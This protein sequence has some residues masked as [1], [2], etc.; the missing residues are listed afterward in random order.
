MCVKIVDKEQASFQIKRQLRFIILFF[1]LFL[2]WCSKGSTWWVSLPREN[3]IHTDLK[4]LNYQEEKRKIKAGFHFP[5]LLVHR[6]EN[7]G[8]SFADCFDDFSPGGSYRENHSPSN[9]DTSDLG[10]Q[11]ADEEIGIW[12]A[13]E[14]LWTISHSFYIMYSQVSKPNLIN[15]HFLKITLCISATF[16]FQLKMEVKF[17]I[18][19][20]LCCYCSCWEGELI[21]PNFF[22][23]SV[24]II[25]S[26][27]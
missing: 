2:Q 25:L 23:L 8:C 16:L 7:T 15:T 18:I 5:S 9:L 20:K 13:W 6:P 10:K 17:S 12:L 14:Q 3:Q 27:A 26:H 21:H 11:N 19:R 24:K 4:S 22:L 1:F